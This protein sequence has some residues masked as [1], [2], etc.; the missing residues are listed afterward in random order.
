MRIA[1]ISEVL[2][3]DRHGLPD[4]AT[5]L[6]PVSCGKGFRLQGYAIFI[7]LGEILMFCAK[8]QRVLILPDGLLL[9]RSR[10]RSTIGGVILGAI[11][12]LVTSIGGVIRVSVSISTLGVFVSTLRVFVST[13]IISTYVSVHDV[14]FLL[15]SCPLGLHPK[16]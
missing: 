3:V 10:G 14:Y 11:S 4:D 16:W 9:L 7:H 2:R 13:L 5:D 8:H 12:A 15:L 6:L 1:E